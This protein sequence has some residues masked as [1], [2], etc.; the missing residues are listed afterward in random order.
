MRKDIDSLL[1]ESINYIFTCYQIKWPI[2]FA[3][4]VIIG[5]FTC[6]ITEVK[7]VDIPESPTVDQFVSVGI[8]NSKSLQVARYG[9]EVLDIE[10]LDAKRALFPSIQVNFSNTDGTVQAVDGNSSSESYDFK[11]VEYD[12]QVGYPI[13]RSFR[14]YNTYK[15]SSIKK[16]VLIARIASDSAAL[17]ARVLDA[18]FNYLK[19]LKILHIRN[20]LRA[21]VHYYVKLIKKKKQVGLI[22]EV[23]YLSSLSNGANIQYSKESTLMDLELAK[24]ILKT[25]T[26][27]KTFPKKITLDIMDILNKKYK[28]METLVLEQ[29]ISIVRTHSLEIKVAHLEYI[30]KK[31]ERKI[32][33]ANTQS[34][35]NISASIGQ[36]AAN[37]VKEALD[38]E[39]SYSI[40][41]N[42]KTGF[43]LHSM[44]SSYSSVKSAPDLGVDSRNKSSSYAVKAN[45]M[46]QLRTKTAHHT[47]ILEEKRAKIALMAK[48][49]EVISELKRS[50]LNYKKAGHQLNT[51]KTRLKYLKKE[52]QISKL[53]DSMNQINPSQ[54]LKTL[55]S[56]SEAQTEKFESIYF[57]L[58]Q[59]T[60][61]EKLI[62]MPIK[63]IE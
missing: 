19:T 14:N 16:N 46:D 34:E 38:Y 51:T 27:S 59:V 35:L 48:E 56:L 39:N 22:S 7:S 45:F 57:Y 49:E 42:F 24:F 8:K 20:K 54:L 15:K 18:L 12:L 11:R 41:I 5:F 63:D 60:E 2:L 10:V 3:L 50:F 52:Y 55:E 43:G 37:Y 13:F 58:K 61:L 9:L 31:Y 47:S 17:K 36:S 25:E 28:T 40:G 6:I 21:E 62:N 44:D 30:E 4:Y 32:A 26:K 23:E 53:K 29:L 1:N 33:R